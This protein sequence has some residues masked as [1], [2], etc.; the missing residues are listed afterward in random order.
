MPHSNTAV[1]CPTV[2]THLV[3]RQ[4]GVFLRQRVCQFL[5]LLC[6]LHVIF[7]RFIETDVLLEHGA[8]GVVQLPEQDTGQTE[9]LLRN[10][11]RSRW[12]LM[13]PACSVPSRIKNK[14]FIFML[15]RLSAG[16]EEI[17]F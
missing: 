6:L 14:C 17:E 5:Q 8:R 10:V 13:Q 7:Q 2:Q 3:Q 12:I 4:G 9:K 11:K 15:D 1:C 16:C